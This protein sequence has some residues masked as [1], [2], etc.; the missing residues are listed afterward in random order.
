[1]KVSNMVKFLCIA[2]PV[3]H[4]GELYGLGKIVESSQ[5]AEDPALNVPINTAAVRYSLLYRCKKCRRIVASGEN[6]LSHE[7][8]GGHFHVRKRGMD[9]LSDN[10]GSVQCTSI[11]VEP[12]RWMTAVQEGGVL[13]KLSCAGCNVRL[14]S[15]NW[16]GTQCSCGTWVVPAFQLHKSRMD[17]SKF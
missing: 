2:W 3:Y 10:S 7:Q 16:A 15:F 4:G 1:M 9:T 12:M 11:F 6:V 13:G 5:F 8:Q 14:G 17:A